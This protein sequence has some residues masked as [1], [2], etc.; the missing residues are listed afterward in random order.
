MFKLIYELVK[1]PLGLPIAWYYEW[2]IL[3]VIDRISYA[4]AYKKVGILYQGD[5]ISGRMA[6][7][8]FHWLIRTIYF[9][10]IWAITYIAILGIKFALSHKM[11]V[12]IGIGITI[13]VSAI[14]WIIWHRNK[15]KRDL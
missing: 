6:G 4:F 12:G 2:I 1:D 14:S 5:F 11:E 15:N 9:I 7:S 8:F 13:V 3:A 10:I